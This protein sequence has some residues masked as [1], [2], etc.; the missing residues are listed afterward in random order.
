MVI[1]QSVEP[2]YRPFRDGTGEYG[3]ISTRFPHSFTVSG[4]FAGLVFRPARRIPIFASLRRGILAR[5]GI[6]GRP[7]KYLA[8]AFAG[9]SWHRSALWRPGNR[10]SALGCGCSSGVEHDLAKVGV[11]GSN[12]F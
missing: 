6:K 11:E 3:R 4:F 1:L 10:P 5:A 8:V 7:S 12:P 9:R 2:G